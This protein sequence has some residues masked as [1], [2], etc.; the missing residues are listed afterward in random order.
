MIGQVAVAC[1]LLAGSGLLGRSF[2]ARL[3]ADR[4][5]EPTNVLTAT[6]PFPRS[7]PA[8]RRV[9]L[10]EAVLARMRARPGVRVAAFGNALPYVSAGGFRAQ[11]IRMPRDPSSEI[12]VNWMNRV[13]SP[14]YFD[15]LRLRVVAGRP[16]TD[17][18]SATSPSVIVVNRSFATRYLSARAVGDRVAPIAVRKDRQSAEVVGVVDDVRQGD[19]TDP[20]QP[21]LFESYRQV[22]ESVQADGPVLVVR[23]AGDPTPYIAVLQ[24]LLREQD[25]SL[26]LDSVMTMEDRIATSLARPRTYAVL[27]GVFASCALAIAAVGLFGLVAYS[28][29]QRTKEIGI[30]MALGALDRQITT[31]VLQHAFVVV[32]VGLIVGLGASLA[33][34]AALRSFLYGVTAHDG[35]TLAGVAAILAAIAIAACLLPTRRALS[36]DPAVALRTE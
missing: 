22:D 29:A 23:T 28:V 1:V 6:L 19:V 27:F 12:E 5:Y 17:A 14:E 26:P 33:L 11:K 9:H 7:Y 34:G 13:V 20:D 8:A 31:L 10:I 18:D 36:V 35:A 2:V 16:L 21:E 15:A 24:S 25:P 4:G 3:H 32:V 30:R